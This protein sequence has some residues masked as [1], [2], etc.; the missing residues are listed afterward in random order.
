M[1]DAVEILLYAEAAGAGAG[2]LGGGLPRQRARK[3]DK[4]PQLAGDPGR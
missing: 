3:G 4:R 1:D 2:R